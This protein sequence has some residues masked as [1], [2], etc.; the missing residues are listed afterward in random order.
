MDGLEG[1]EK[2]LFVVD[3]PSVQLQIIGS[4]A[5]VEELVESVNFIMQ[6]VVRYIAALNCDRIEVSNAALAFRR[7]KHSSL[8]QQ[9]LHT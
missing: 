3:C 6:E 9:S 5:L 4:F 7:I 1:L 2:A 8:R